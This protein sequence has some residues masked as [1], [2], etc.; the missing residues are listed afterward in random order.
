VARDH[1]WRRRQWSGRGRDGKRLYDRKLLEFGNLNPSGSRYILTSAGNDAFLY[2]L[3]TNG[4]F[5]AAA[6][7]VSGYR[8]NAGIALAIDGSG[9][10]YAT[11]G[12]RDTANFNPDPSS[13]PVYM[14]TNNSA[15]YP[16][17]LDV[18]VSQL[19]QTQPSGPPPSARSAYPGQSL[20]LL[21][22]R[23][24]ITAIAP[25]PA[26]G[27]SQGHSEKVPVAQNT[28]GAVLKS[29]NAEQSPRPAFAPPHTVTL[30]RLF[31][32]PLGAF[33]PLIPLA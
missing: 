24:G 12:F 10:I 28:L 2:E 15:A 3:D 21:L 19:M 25:I 27:V 33:T 23:G 8:T 7:I 9:N 22:Q 1:P 16:Y 4:S 17:H 6:D 30:D 32:A 26:S 29:A 31:A 18:F 14:E 11:G 5:V 20:A 13:Q